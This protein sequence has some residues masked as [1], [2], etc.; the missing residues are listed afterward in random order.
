ML[1]ACTDDVGE[2]KMATRRNFLKG[3]FSGVVLLGS[4]LSL[5]KVR[6][7][8]KHEHYMAPGKWN[9][10]YVHN[11]EWHLLSD[12][13]DSPFEFDSRDDAERYVVKA[14]LTRYPQFNDPKV[15]SIDGTVVWTRAPNQ[16]SNFDDIRLSEEEAELRVSLMEEDG[17]YFPQ[18]VRTHIKR[19]L[20]ADH[21]GEQAT[22]WCEILGDRRYK[23][24]V[25]AVW[26]SGHDPYRKMLRR[27][28]YNN[29]YHSVL[30]KLYTFS[31]PQWHR[32]EKRVG[33]V[34]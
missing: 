32:W 4:G 2:I 16:I 11:E 30:G 14:G 7:Y 1:A 5:S 18:E 28:Y 8:H 15:T 22:I 20:V 31:P 29:G 17:G 3:I 9:I 13:F 19:M 27:L 34:T 12:A 21:G 24:S 10:W 33:R 23:K 26:K 6:V 25:V